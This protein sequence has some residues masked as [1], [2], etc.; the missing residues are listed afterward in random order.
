MASGLV[1]FTNTSYDDARTFFHLA[2]AQATTLQV[3]TLPRAAHA[4]LWTGDIEGARADLAAVDATGVHGPSVEADRRT[5]RAGIAAAEGRTSEALVLYREG[6]RAWRDLGLDLDEA[7]CGL[8]AVHMLGTTEPEVR[9]IADSTREI[10]AR[11]GAT[12]FLA[13]LDTALAGA[14][15]PGP[16]PRSGIQ[17]GSV[18]EAGFANAS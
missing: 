5:I 3:V 2:G 9:Q 12:P 7:L 11:L 17:A 4:A 13:R 8:D 15:A 6:L 14:A 1:A 18:A 16:G 10:L